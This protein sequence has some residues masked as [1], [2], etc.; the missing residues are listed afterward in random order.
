MMQYSDFQP[1]VCQSA[2]QYLGYLMDKQ[3]KGF[4]DSGRKV[5][6]VNQIAPGRVSGEY[7]LYTNERVIHPEA[8]EIWI[9]DQRIAN[10]DII[11]TQ[12]V[13][14]YTHT[15]RIADNS[16]HLKKDRN[17][18]T[19]DIHIVSDL[20]FLI[21]RLLQFYKSN[22]FTFTPPSPIN[23]PP[24]PDNLMRDLSQEQIE[25][26][27]A[28]FQA[29]ISYIS[30]APGTGKTKAVLAR[31]I[32]RYVLAK[33][34]IFLLAPTN[35]AVEQML[36]GVLP[37][38]KDAGID[39]SKVYRL[40]TATERF[41]QE[42]P[43]VIGDTAAEALLH[44]LLEQKEHYETQIGKFRDLNEQAEAL[45]SRIEKCTAAHRQI[46]DLAH[47]VKESHTATEQLAEQISELSFQLNR[48]KSEFEQAKNA[49][50]AAAVIVSFCE[51]SI[52]RTQ[53]RIKRL[54]F[55]FWKKAVRYQMDNELRLLLVNLPQYKDNHANAAT[56]L[57]QAHRHYEIMIKAHAD[58]Q[59]KHRRSIAHC[60][61][62]VKEIKMHAEVDSE[63]KQSVYASILDTKYELDDASAFLTRLKSQHQG[64]VEQIDYDIL[65]ACK[66]EIQLIDKQLAGIGTNAKMRQKENA[67]VFAG[68]IDSS[69]IEIGK[70]KKPIHHVFLDEAGY[71]CLAKGMTAFACGA[72]VTF[73]GDHKQ[74]PPVC[75]MDRIKQEYAPVILWAL[76]VAYYPEL[77]YGTFEDLYHRCYVKNEEPSFQGMEYRSLNTSYRFGPGL[78][79]ILAKHIYTSKFQGVSSSPFEIEII[80]A[81]LISGTE[82][83]SLSEANCIR[84][85]IDCNPGIDFVVL[86]PYRSQIKLLKRTLPKEYK[87]NILTVHRSQ[88][89][90]WDTVILSVT[91]SYRP[92]FT[93][94]KL[95][96]G[97]SV[98]NTAISRAKCKLIIVCDITAWNTKQGQMVTELIDAGTIIK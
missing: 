80:D 37:I 16:G 87:E 43:Q 48:A 2:E 49:A 95:P 74:L 59:D 25:A 42:Y 90:E 69:L 72:P 21:R 45:S 30:G 31:C 38:L 23:V 13:N 32:L 57:E 84:S 67:L 54:R 44:S 19:G 61:S 11:T 24:L 68:T 93:N 60:A 5:I 6:S 46:S 88:G 12:T 71:T 89:C 35:N 1:I 91:D 47:Q 14:R 82:R 36:R 56:T 96:I 76:P 97:R 17:L 7:L 64:L 65:N 51:D 73:L 50:S 52:S 40:G 79:K 77:M 98:L 63:Y 33:K 55:C 41:A 86:A 70:P 4:W 62:L 39:L 3:N 81:P 53:K 83:T 34:R 10:I 75:E 28:V 85:Y 26:V 66:A 15:V 27:N 92:F 94:S 22:R 29:P 9:R 20:L 8:S 18:S 78:A 58:R